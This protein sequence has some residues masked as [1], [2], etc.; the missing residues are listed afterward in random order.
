MTD[1]RN[2]PLTHEQV[3]YAMRDTYYL[4]PAGMRLMKELP[5]PRVAGAMR[6]TYKA[7][8]K[9]AWKPDRPLIWEEDNKV[10]KITPATTSTARN[11]SA[12][13]V[14]DRRERSLM[15]NVREDRNPSNAVLR[16]QAHDF[17]KQQQGVLGG[18]H[19]SPRL[20]ALLM[21]AYQSREAVS[22]WGDLRSPTHS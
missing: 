4:R 14:R 19:F 21:A 18:S 8:R 16:T 17:C 9:V 15:G 2:R 12:A 6:L 5:R 22:L 1:W 7:V 10:A 3:I 13:L 11:V 20:S